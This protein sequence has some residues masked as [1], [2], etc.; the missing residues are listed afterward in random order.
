MNH[1]FTN[2]NKNRSIQYEKS[3]FTHQLQTGKYIRL[4][5]DAQLI[6]QHFRYKIAEYDK[7]NIKSEIAE[8]GNVNIN[9]EERAEKNLG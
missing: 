6:Q 4:T 3:Y 9:M 5:E 7:Q 8:D 1:E 2:N